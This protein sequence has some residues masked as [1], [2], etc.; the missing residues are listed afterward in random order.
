MLLLLL[1]LLSPSLLFVLL[2]LIFI[3]VC[4]IRWFSIYRKSYNYRVME[5]LIKYNFFCNEILLSTTNYNC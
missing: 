5:Q 2:L 3:T 1:F 4:T